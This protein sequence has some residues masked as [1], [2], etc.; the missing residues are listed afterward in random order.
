MTQIG[1]GGMVTRGALLRPLESAP[2]RKSERFE[3]KINEV[4]LEDIKPNGDRYVVEV[5]DLDEKIELGQILVVTQDPSINP[6]DPS[7]NPNVEQRG[8]L[9]AV[10]VRAGN[11]HLLGLPDPRLA[12]RNISG[13]EE[14]ER[15]PADVPMFF[16]RGDVVFV[17][18]NAKG[19]ALR[20]LGREGRIVNQIDVLARLE[21]GG[22]PVRLVRE[23]G[24][25]MLPT[26]ATE[27]IET[28]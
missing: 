6:R 12:V 26:E 3:L 16:E 20:I 14:V 11:G 19:R 2:V 7:A 28:V 23:D 10:V 13:N 18:R 9:T 17:D 4:D 5:I 8:V 15:H 24:I 22:K 27:T 21:L 25:W 1:P